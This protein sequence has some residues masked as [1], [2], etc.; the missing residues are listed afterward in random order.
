MPGE[1]VALISAGGTFLR[2]A[3]PERH[4]LMLTEGAQISIDRASGTTQGRLAK[5]YPL[6]ENGR[7]I[8]DVEMPDASDRFVDA[9]V[10]VRLPMD[11]RQALMVPASALV[12]QAGLDFVQ[13]ETAAGPVLRSVVPGG[14]IETETGDMVE[15]LS[16][17]VAGDRIVTD[18]AQGANRD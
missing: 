17:L 5:V 14:R 16:G 9:R 3:V 12:S 8:A 15:I 6:V 7:V 2:L 4:A 11:E 13:V 1:S 18:P 10:L